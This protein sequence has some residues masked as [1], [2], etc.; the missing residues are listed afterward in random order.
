MASFARDFIDRLTRPF[1]GRLG[2]E[3][4]A[5]AVIVLEHDFTNS[6]GWTLGTSCTINAG[7]LWCNNTAANVTNSY[8]IALSAGTYRV[9]FDIVAPY[10][11]GDITPRFNTSGGVVSGPIYSLAGGT[12]TKTADIVVPNTITQFQFRVTR[13]G[14]AMDCRLDNLIVTKLS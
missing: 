12:G 4:V 1:S 10:N 5:S 11:A 3:E 7:T 8:N 6:T 14:T 2:R 13:D 9:Q